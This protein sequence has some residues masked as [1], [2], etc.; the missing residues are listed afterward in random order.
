L[1]FI[2]SEAGERRRQKQ[3]GERK[4][5]DGLRSHLLALE[6]KGKKKA[7]ARDVVVFKAGENAWEEEK[8]RRASIFCIPLF[9]KKRK[10]DEDY[11]CSAQPPPKSMAHEIRGK[12][13]SEKHALIYFPK[14]EMCYKTATTQK[15]RST[16][17]IAG[18]KKGESL[19]M[20]CRKRGRKEKEEEV[21]LPSL[22]L[23]EREKGNSNDVK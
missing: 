7:K 1:I 4:R 11:K 8:E 23:R 16:L 9:I 17:S 2:G 14:G 15:R 6:E 12:R 3:G 13:G 22:F 21:D 19:A 20:P 10:E 5:S 18:R